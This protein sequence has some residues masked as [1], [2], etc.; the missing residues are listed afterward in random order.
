MPAAC[1]RRPG[2]RGDRLGAMVGSWS[3]ILAKVACQTKR[4]PCILCTAKSMRL[5]AVV[6]R[7]LMNVDEALAR[8][9]AIRGQLTHGETFRGYRSATVAATG[10]LGLAAAA[11][12]P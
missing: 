2:R 12:Q 6:E 3:G 10:C 11:M 8:I 9:S 1:A 5:W 4:E 7:L